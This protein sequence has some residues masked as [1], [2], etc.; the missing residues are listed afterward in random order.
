MALPQTLPIPLLTLIAEIRGVSV[1]PLE[2]GNEEDENEQS[3]TPDVM[4]ENDH[5]DNLSYS[6]ASYSDYSDYS[7]HSEYS[8]YSGYSDNS[9]NSEYSAYSDYSDY[10][11]GYD[12]TP[13]SPKT[14]KLSKPSHTAFARYRPSFKEIS[15]D[16]GSDRGDNLNNGEL[17]GK[18]S[19]HSHSAQPSK[20]HQRDRS[21]SV[22]GRSGWKLPEGTIEKITKDVFSRVC[23]GEVAP[24]EKV[25]QL[26][27]QTGVP[28]TILSSAC[29]MVVFLMT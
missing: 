10:S 25:R 13:K 27:E 29:V 21:G 19:H 3:I 2:G 9:D 4:E 26:F 15:P 5:D 1:T 18:S 24:L 20:E 6:A 8:E 17:Q 11:D 16:V 14:P 12:E 22:E 7:D 28:P 23:E